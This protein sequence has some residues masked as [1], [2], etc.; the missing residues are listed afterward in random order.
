MSSE[1]STPSFLLPGNATLDFDNY[2]YGS[3][4]DR[5]SDAPLTAADVAFAL[6]RY[7][8]PVII[9]VGTTGNLVSAAVMLRG[10]MRATSMYCY[11]L[12]LA[13]VDTVVLFVSAFKTWIRLVS[14]V[15]WLHASSGACKTIMFLLL[16]SLH[17]SAWL[18]VVVSADRFQPFSD[19]AP[20]IFQTV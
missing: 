8:F 9:V 11:L 12:V 19:R 16:V 18:I 2:T 20:L 14:G 5:D 1:Q 15:E 4:Y 7:L 6:V 3:T 17:L 10:R 13:V